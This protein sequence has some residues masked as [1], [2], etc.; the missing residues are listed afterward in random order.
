METVR[1][2]ILVNFKGPLKISKRCKYIKVV[3]LDHF[4][5]LPAMIGAFT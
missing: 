1:G 5:K 2:P 3:K 4:C